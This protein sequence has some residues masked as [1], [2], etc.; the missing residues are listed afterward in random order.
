M[1][2]L[3]APKHWSGY[4]WTYSCQKMALNGQNYH[5]FYIDPVVLCLS[6]ILVIGMF[7]LIKSKELWDNLLPKTLKMTIFQWK[8]AKKLPL[9]T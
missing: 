1:N 2:R 6:F 8:M 4:V 5:N 9:M 7:L 3:I